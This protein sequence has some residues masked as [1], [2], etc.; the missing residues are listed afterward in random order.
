[1]FFYELNYRYIEKVDVCLLNNASRMVEYESI[2][3]VIFRPKAF[4]LFGNHKAKPSDNLNMESLFPGMNSQQSLFERLYNFKMERKQTIFTLE[5]SYR[6]DLGIHQFLNAQFYDKKMM[7]H[8][9]MNNDVNNNNN[10]HYPLTDFQM[11][12]FKEDALIVNLLRKMISVANPHQFKYAIIVP[13][14]CVDTFNSIP[15]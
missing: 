4:L 11:I 13:P 2:I 15:M 3:P 12:H 6:F 8:A 10:R 5:T 7:Y 14:N 9:P 1:M